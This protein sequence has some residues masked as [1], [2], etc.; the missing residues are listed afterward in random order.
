MKT[1]EQVIEQRKA[2][3]QKKQAKYISFPGMTVIK[4]KF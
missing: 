2:N 1:K 3:I 4:C